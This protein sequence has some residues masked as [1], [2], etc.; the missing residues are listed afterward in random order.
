[1]LE[2]KVKSIDRVWFGV[3]YRDR[4][5]E[6]TNF[7]YSE[8]ELTKSLLK[9]V[10]F[11]EPFQINS[12]PSPFA[13]GILALIKSVYDGK[14]SARKISLDLERLP[15]YSQRVLRTVSQ[16]PLGYV[17]SYGGVAE[18]AGGGARAVGNVMAANPFA[19]II[20]CHRVVTSNLALG[21]YGGG[22]KTKLHLLQREKQGF[23]K[24][25]RIANG[26]KS[27]QVFPVELVL[28]KLEGTILNCHNET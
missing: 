13:D 25:E 10:P 12:E 2:L 21:G 9:M 4:I 22:L 15:I 8:S 19:P 27:L 17:A 11:N 1:L 6:T 16:I 3:S 26:E 5:V 7:G 24:T 14:G 23:T 18:A 20:P 28:E